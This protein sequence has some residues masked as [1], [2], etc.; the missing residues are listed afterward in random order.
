MIYPFKIQCSH[1]SSMND[2][3]RLGYVHIFKKQ[4]TMSS[5]IHTQKQ[6]HHSLLY[7]NTSY[8]LTRFNVICNS[9]KNSYKRHLKYGPL[10]KNTTKKLHE[11]V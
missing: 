1:G 7:S 2:N 8:S 6:Q 5:L 4:T 11:E 9:K 3:N 10:H